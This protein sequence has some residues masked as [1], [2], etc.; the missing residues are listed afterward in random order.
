MAA[1]ATAFGGE[2]A[3]SFYLSSPRRGLELE[4]ALAQRLIGEAQQ[5]C[6]HS[7]GG[8]GEP[9]VA[10]CLADVRHCDH[11]VLILAGRYGTPQPEHN[12][13]SVT[14]LEFEEAV[15]SGRS[16]RAF[17][18]NFISD[19]SNGLDDPEG[20]TRLAAFKDRVQR[21]CTARVCDNLE[22]FA[23]AIKVLAAAPPPRP[24][25]ATAD[26]TLNAEETPHNLP[27]RA[28]GGDGLSGRKLALL[29]LEDLLEAGEGP[30][31][32]TGMDGVGKTALALHHLRRQ[33]ARY[34]GGVVLLDGQQQ[35]AGLVAQL[36]LFARAH[37]GQEPPQDL[38]AAARLAWLYG[39]WP[40]SQPVLLLLDELQ[41]PQDLANLGRG[42]PERFR[43]LVTSR[44][45]VGAARQRVPLAPL[46]DQDALE[47]L[48]Q[49][50]ERGPFTEEE[51]IQAQS[52]A[53]EVGGL[54]LALQLLGR[55]LARDRDLELAELADRL[56]QRGALARELQGGSGDPE[57]ERGLQAGFQIAYDQLTTAE[58]ELGLLLAEL[59]PTAAPWDLLALCRPPAL[60]PHAWEEARLG[61]EQQH[62]LER[63]LARLYQ[64]HPLLHD[65]LGAQAGNGRGK[66]CQRREREARLAGA[67]TT[68]LAG[69]S[70]VLEARS[71]ERN[72]RCLPLLEALA[73][74]P[75]QRWTGATSCLPLL[76]LGRLR[77][78]LGAD[79]LAEE[80]LAAALQRARATASATATATAG[81]GAPGQGA[82]LE[83]GCLVALAGIARGRGQLDSAERRCREALALL[84]AAEGRSQPDRD[85]LALERAEALNGLGLALHDLGSPEAEAVLRQALKLRLQ[86]LDHN[87]RQVQISRNNLARNLAAEG[88][89]E[90]AEALYHQVL[91]ALG[92]EACE[93]AVAA[94]NNLASLALGEERLEEAHAELR[95]AV[96]LAAKALGESH[97]L[98]GV[99]LRNLGIVAEK[100]G[101]LKEAEEHYSKAVE[102]VTA[103]WGTEDPRS[104]DCRLTWEAFRAEGSR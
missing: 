16:L 54:P 94:H 40:G 70:D 68:W 7:Y 42:L 98:R 41:D 22:A 17:F 3:H 87:G 47:L 73:R 10:T 36:A 8:S 19:F 13:K 66:A 93:V 44:R 76:A 71:L 92:E 57:V 88:R 38:P 14:E 12:G 15:A 20:L 64:L 30:V 55:Q 97:P 50:A 18:L 89:G 45:Q 49:V 23:D 39:H 91:R 65:L 25:L 34:R 60:E 80:A 90:E 46:A 5:A 72:Q 69:V 27:Y 1:L 79:D 56:R 59:P 37:F 67:L 85:G 103:A 9:P 29:Q 101:R 58:R 95:E 78:G 100:L 61:L 2:P 53:D 81:S 82:V 96:R 28:Y 51:R 21:H 43:I 99:L 74:W 48:E 11:Y 84:E 62:L 83:A 26:P 104:Q 24:A 102:L 77:A 33:L 75:V 35:L 52:L 4:R 6:R 63:P 86:H 31:L 32:I